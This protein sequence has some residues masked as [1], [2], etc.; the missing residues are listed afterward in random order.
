[1]VRA[2]V[3]QRLLQQGSV[4]VPP[5]QSQGADKEGQKVGDAHNVG[6][7]SLCRRRARRYTWHNSAL[8][9]ARPRLRVWSRR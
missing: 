1:M 6:K 5:A 4:N 9:A 3:K 2:G 8:V 7:S